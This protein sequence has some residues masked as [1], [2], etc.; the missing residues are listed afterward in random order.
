MRLEGKVAIVTGG[1]GAIGRAVAQAF[2]GE[3]ASVVVADVLGDSAEAAAAAI[4]TAGG[5]AIGV[6][7]D[8]SVRSHV[9][10]LAD[11]AESAFGVATVAFCC[12]GITS[13]AA[14]PHC[15]S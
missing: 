13:T 2:A 8:V 11:A 5:A 9:D 14:P 4:A 1:A 12:A 7:A 3:G 6:R 10:A 15:S